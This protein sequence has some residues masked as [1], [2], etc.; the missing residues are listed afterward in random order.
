MINPDFIP[1]SMTSDARWK[2]IELV[3]KEAREYQN[4]VLHC[5]TNLQVPELSSV[6]YLEDG[7]VKSRLQLLLSMLV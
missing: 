3:R 4:G 5:G 7:E 2:F 6:Y 1:A